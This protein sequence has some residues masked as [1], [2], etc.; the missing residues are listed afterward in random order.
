MLTSIHPRNRVFAMHSD[1]LSTKQA[2]KKECDIHEILKQYQ[3]TGIINHIQSRQAEFAD[4][5]AAMDYQEAIEIVRT[6][7]EGFSELPSKV[8]ERFANDPFNLL[9]ALNDPGMRDELVELGIL[10][11]PAAAPA[12][13]AAPVSAD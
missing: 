4:L 7:Q 6:A 1:K 13:Q 3:K 12:P 5:P 9:A 8:R 2:H 10:N 11:A